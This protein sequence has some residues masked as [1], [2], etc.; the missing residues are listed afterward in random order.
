MD[1]IL[2]HNAFIASSFHH[3]LVNQSLSVYKSHLVNAQRFFFSSLRYIKIAVNMLLSCHA[4]VLK[5]EEL[6]VL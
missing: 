5:S 4:N 1:S 6:D 3:F 2:S